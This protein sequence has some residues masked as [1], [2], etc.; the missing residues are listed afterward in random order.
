MRY[1][2]IGDIHG[3]FRALE[4]LAKFAAFSADD[5]VIAL[6]DYVGKG[7]DTR[8]VIDWLIDY[9]ARAPLIAL[10][11]NHEILLLKARENKKEFLAW[12]DQ[13]GDGTLASY[14]DKLHPSSASFAEVPPAHWK[15]VESTLRYYE[16]D[17]HF[18]VHANASPDRPL[19]E[20]SDFVLFWE[21]FR[22]PPRHESGK[23]MVCGHTSQRSFEPV[24]IGHA[25]CLDTRCY[26]GGWLSCLDA[27]SGILWQASEDGQTR[28][29][30][31][32]DYL[33]A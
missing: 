33:R 11:G 3:C 6:G 27:K 9:R 26:G 21:K 17:S 5:V 28:K 14:T 2:A 4:T 32:A 1:L 16:I 10:R 13:G 7:P 30:N 24:N 31:I 19:A 18:F 8:R 15:F 23:T 12:L 25:V 20:Q 29:G 22:N